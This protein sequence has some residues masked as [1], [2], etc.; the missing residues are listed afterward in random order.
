MRLGSNHTQQSK[1]RGGWKFAPEGLGARACLLGKNGAFL[2]TLETRFLA[3]T[4]VSG[5]LQYALKARPVK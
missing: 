2:E 5:A 1:K 4:W 3:I